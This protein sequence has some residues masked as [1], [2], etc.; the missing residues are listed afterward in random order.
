MAN[1]PQDGPHIALACLLEVVASGPPSSPLRTHGAQST[2]RPARALNVSD[3]MHP[4][5]G[6]QAAP[7]LGPRGVRG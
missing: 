3:F 1:A 5:I 6:R 4:C 7:L 2:P